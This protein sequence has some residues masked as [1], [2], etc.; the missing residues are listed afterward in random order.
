MLQG[1]TH[2]LEGG[3]GLVCCAAVNALDPVGLGDG[4][5]FK[6]ILLLDE[7]QVIS[8]GWVEVILAGYELD[9]DGVFLGFEE[10]GV[11]KVEGD[12][13]RAGLEHIFSELYLVG[14][15]CGSGVGCH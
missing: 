7:G 11:T 12:E 1:W 6:T 10:C 14:K 2:D 5:L 4:T 3:K 13:C 15:Y 8:I 9:D